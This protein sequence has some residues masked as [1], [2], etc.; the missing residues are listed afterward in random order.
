[1]MSVNSAAVRPI[2]RRRP[3]RSASCPVAKAPRA[4]P[5]VKAERKRP[6]SA[7]DAPSWTSRSGPVGKSWNAAKKVRKVKTQRSRKPR[8]NR[9]VWGPDMSALSPEGGEE[10]E[11]GEGP[12]QQ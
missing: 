4:E 1:M 2:M 9:R 8:D 3:M 5:T 6:L 10:S 7:F 11:E 12:H